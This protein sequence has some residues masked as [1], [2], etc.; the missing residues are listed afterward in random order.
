MRLGGMGQPLDPDGMVAT[1]RRIGVDRVA[2]GTN[3][4][5][6]DQV[7]YAQA[8]RSLPLDDDELAQ[9]GYANAARLWGDR[10]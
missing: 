3:Y 10:T 8:L 9:V 1:I 5:M 7:G 4:P 6:M 2:F